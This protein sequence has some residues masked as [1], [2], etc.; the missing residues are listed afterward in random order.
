MFPTK[1][2]GNID[3]L[4]SV[5]HSIF[6]NTWWDCIEVIWGYLHNTTDSHMKDVP[7]LGGDS[8]GSKPYIDIDIDIDIEV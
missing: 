4:L 3:F 6:V 2:I 1:V 5:G 7:A 8:V